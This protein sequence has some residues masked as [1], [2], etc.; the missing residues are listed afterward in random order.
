MAPRA[1]K[2]GDPAT[3]AAALILRL[4][5]IVLAILVPCASVVS[6]RPLFILMPIGAVLLIIGS[7]LAPGPS[8]HPIGR[9]TRS[10]LSP[11]GLATLIFVVWAGLS[12][13]WT[14]FPGIALERFLKTAGTL[15]VAFVAMASLP[16]HMRASNS[17]LLPIGVAAAALAIISV[18]LVA[19]QNILGGDADGNT[20]RRATIA[21]VILVWPALGALAIRERVATA[22]VVAVGVA[23]AAAAV[24]TPLAL[25]ALILAILAFSFAFSNPVATG[26]GL[27]W[28]SAAL[29]LL[30]PALPLAAT[31][32]LPS[33]F[34]ASGPLAMF[35]VWAE[36]IQTDGLRLLTGHG[37]DTSVRAAL[38][39]RLPPGAPT[40]LLF[41]VWYDFGLIGAC[42]TAAM[43][44][45]AFNV[46]G[47]AARVI[48]PFLLAALASMLVLGVA[49]EALSQL[50]WVT[51]LCAAAIYF[52]IVM[53]AQHRPDR[54]RAQVATTPAQPA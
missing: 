45:A 17:N 40:G 51:V 1:R 13:A 31:A 12:F 11:L 25:S 15:L 52:A 5:M 3:D 23:I 38:A 10:I 50:W 18:A 41:E 19:P 37:F 26:R 2:T 39:G 35:P 36:V 49:G 16:E 6:R 33:R 30:A 32:L 4:G 44:F 48:A 53:R 24:W 27:G 46:A 20:V 34:D 42:A 8:T 29:I 22:G 54:V 47:H 43:A 21:I 9:V 14:P 7:R 28:L